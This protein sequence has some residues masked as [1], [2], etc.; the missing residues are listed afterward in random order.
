MRISI[1][2]TN[3]VPLYLQVA[4][5]VRA[6]IA[7]GHLVV[8]EPLPSLRDLAAELRVNYHT[9]A[10]AYQLLQDD[11]AIERQ[12][13]GPYTVAAH[14]AETSATELVRQE[15]ERLVRYA[16]SL[17]IGSDELFTMLAEL[18]DRLDDERAEKERA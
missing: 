9:V 5:G 8:G 16:W 3:G 18:W 14:A 6:S 13:G 4:E 1:D 15:A 2:P 12:R 11:G 10:K 17:G 7:A